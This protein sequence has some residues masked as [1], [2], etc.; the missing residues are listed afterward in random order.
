MDVA[1]MVVLLEV[2]PISNLELRQSDHRVLGSPFL[3]RPFSTTQFDQAASSRKSPGCFKLL[4]FK[5][6][7]GH[8]VLPIPICAHFPQQP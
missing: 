6:Y 3:P 8:C 4:P 2:S 1:V 5:N 7:G